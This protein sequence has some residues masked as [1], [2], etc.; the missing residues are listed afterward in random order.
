M[1]RVG[2]GG[3]GYVS[4]QLLGVKRGLER[5]R[6]KDGLRGW[7]VGRRRVEMERREREVEGERSVK[8]LVRRFTGK[9]DMA[10][11]GDGVEGR[12]GRGAIAGEKRR[13]GEPTRAHVYGL[14]RFWEDMGKEGTAC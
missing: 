4:P 10:R 8:G 12:W 11:R 13:R 14:R 3:G 7:L 5:E 9:A 1:A 6:V 2:G